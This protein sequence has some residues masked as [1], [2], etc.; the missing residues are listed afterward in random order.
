[1]KLNKVLLRHQAI[2]LSGSG[3]MFIRYSDSGVD[4][5]THTF[6]SYLKE[7]PLFVLI[8]TILNGLHLFT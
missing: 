7:R 5:N 8:V 1:M 3:C 2:V 6:S 4:L